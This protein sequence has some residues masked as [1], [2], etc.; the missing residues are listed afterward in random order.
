[1]KEISIIDSAQGAIT[2]RINYELQK[3][4]ENINDVNTK[5]GAKRKITVTLEL[6]PDESRQHIVIQTVVK[7]SLQ[8]TFPINSSLFLSDSGLI[9]MTAQTQGQYSLEGEMEERPN[10]IP[11]KKAE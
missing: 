5:A 9:E 6:L 8:P 1:M 10:I 4:V 11:I 7:S 3:V 2:E